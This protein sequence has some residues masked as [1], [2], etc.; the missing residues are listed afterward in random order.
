LEINAEGRYKKLLENFKKKVFGQQK[1][2][3][4]QKG[5]ET[6]RKQNTGKGIP[7]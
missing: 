6:D 5:I 4:G 1:E 2:T 3:R 7:S